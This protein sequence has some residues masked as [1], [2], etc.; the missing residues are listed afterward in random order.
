MEYFAV[1]DTET[2]ISDRVMSVGIVIAETSSFKM[3]DERYYI[4][5]PEYYIEGMYTSELHAQGR[6]H[7]E[8]ILS[9]RKTI[10]KIEALF[11][12]YKVEKIFAYNASF[13]KKHLVE[14]SSYG[15]FDIMKIAAYK[16]YNDRIPATVVCCK[17]GRMKCNFGV[18]SMM[19]ILSG[20]K[21]YREKH[22][23]ICDA[24]DEL[25]L[26]RL[27]GKALDIYDVAKCK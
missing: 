22:N 11:S 13:D 27:L 17:T 24:L 10:S 19:R 25:E 15:W 26:M 14:L 1:I 12:T 21:R 3:V 6:A 2:N 9:R 23:A 18:E 16:Q 4:I 7:K 20:N 5:D 8:E